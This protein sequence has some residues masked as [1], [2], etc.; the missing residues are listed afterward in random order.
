M[1][2]ILGLFGFF[3]GK[4]KDED[5][6]SYFLDIISKVFR[7]EKIS[8]HFFLNGIVNRIRKQFAAGYS[9]KEAG[10]R[11]LCSLLY[12]RELGVLGDYY[13]GDDMNENKIR[14]IASNPQ[15]KNSTEK[16]E[17]IF[18]EFPDFFY[19][20]STRAVF[21]LGS[22]AQLLLDVQYAE[23]SATPFRTKLQG[24]RLDQRK[25]TAL[26]PEIQNKFDE[27]NKSYYRELEKLASEYL[28]QAGEN[29]GLSK[30]EVSFYFVLGMNLASYLKAHKEV[31]NN[32]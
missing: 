15:H 20:N 9:T 25:V 24:L 10:L 30:D 5:L 32:E 29:W 3:F 13:H 23:R 21:T 16:L 7:N 11:G 28:I 12:L 2:L 4:R 18:A 1:N 8:Y 31:K 22:L 17:A 19:K 26:L 14:N 27:Y 6:S